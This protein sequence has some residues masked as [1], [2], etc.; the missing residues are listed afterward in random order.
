MT[1]TWHIGTHDGRFAV[2]RD[3]FLAKTKGGKVRTFASAQ[4]AQGAADV[5]NG[6]AT[7]ATREALEAAL[8]PVTAKHA[9]AIKGADRR[10]E[11]AEADAIGRVLALAERE[12]DADIRLRAIESALKLSTFKAWKVSTG[13]VR[14]AHKTGYIALI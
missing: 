2:E 12:R 13:Q 1:D 7:K 8:V 9:A 11:Q 14:V 3:G 10:I 4:K 5:L 6:A